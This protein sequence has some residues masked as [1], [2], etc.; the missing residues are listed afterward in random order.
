MPSINVANVVSNFD[1]SSVSSRDV[2]APSDAANRAVYIWIVLDG[3]GGSIASSG[4]TAVL[5]NI[6]IPSSSTTARAALL[7]KEEGGSPPAAY[8]VTSS[9][10]RAAWLC[11]AVDGDNGIDG[12]PPTPSSGDSSTATC[13]AATPSEAG[14]LVLRLVATD[15]TSLSHGTIS[16]YT[17][18][19]SI[20]QPSGGTVSGQYKELATADALG[21]ENVSLGTSEQWTAATV[22]ILGD[23]GG[24]GHA[25]VLVNAT[26]LKSKLRGLV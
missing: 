25:G 24:G 13:P 18:I 6:P 10:E 20:E 5:D 26:P 8:T 7:R 16:G 17:V 19:D 12:T 11:W 1:S 15:N 22:I 3:N 23:G 21:T 2:D 9:S 14:C 4:F